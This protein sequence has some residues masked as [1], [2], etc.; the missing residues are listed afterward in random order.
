MKKQQ[1]VTISIVTACDMAVLCICLS[2]FKQFQPI[3]SDLMCI[4]IIYKVDY[5]GDETEFESLINILKERQQ[6]ESKWLMNFLANRTKYGERCFP[7]LAS[8]TEPGGGLDKQRKALYTDLA[9]FPVKSHLQVKD[10]DR[11][12]QNSV[13]GK[14]GV[15]QAEN[16]AQALRT[17]GPLTDLHFPNTSDVCERKHRR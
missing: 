2:H 13:L 11:D 7:A 4:Y 16:T 3:T 9:I 10:I 5:I 1:Q 14:R 6:L 12:S 8:S 17:K 15:S